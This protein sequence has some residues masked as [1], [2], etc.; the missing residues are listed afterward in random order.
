MGEKERGERKRE[1]EIASEREVPTTTF[2]SLFLATSCALSEREFRPPAMHAQRRDRARLYSG[3]ERGSL[4]LDGVALRVV[5]SP[6][7][8]FLPPSRQRPDL[9]RRKRGG[10]P[11]SFPSFFRSPSFFLSLPPPSSQP[12]L[13]P[14]ETRPRS[15]TAPAAATG[16]PRP[17]PRTRASATPRRRP[18][19]TK[20]ATATPPPLR[21]RTTPR[22]TR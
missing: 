5:M 21:R 10:S 4:A 18:R 22:T 19:P 13:P 9:R 17:T 3:R 12:L 11:L 16:A 1:K 14:S 8:S 15:A 20:T 2:G 7:F 6:R